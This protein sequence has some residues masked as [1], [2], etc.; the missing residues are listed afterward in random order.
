MSINEEQPLASAGAGDSSG[1]NFRK[2]FSDVAVYSTGNLLIKGLSLI[3]A[4]IFT[5]IFI[6]AQYGAWSYINV[7]VA[8]MTGILLLG[9]D[10]AYTRYFFQCESEEEKQTLTATWLAFLA[11]WSIV[12]IAAIL[13]FSGALASWMLGEDGYRAAWVIGLVSSPLAMM[14]LSLAQALRN[15]FRAKEFML[16]NLATAILTISL[17]VLFVLVFDLGVAGALLGA[18]LASLVMIPLRLWVI[19]DLLSQSFSLQFLKKLLI[20][21][22]PLVP[23]NIAFWLFSNA[24]RLMLARLASLEEVGIYSIAGSMAAVIML[25]QN[26]IGLSWLPHGIKTYEEDQIMAAQVFRKIMI[27]FLA[28]SGFIITGFV[29]LAQEVL[30]ILVP[31]AYYAAFTVIPFLAAGFIFFTSAHVSV[32]AIMV[33]NKTVY[34]MIACWAIAVLNIGLNFLLIPRFGI[35]GAGAATGISYMFFAGS[36]A[37]ISRQLWPVAYPGKLIALLLI[38]PLVAVGLIALIANYGP[39]VFIN[40]SLKILVLVISGLILARLANLRL[41]KLMQR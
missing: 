17:A 1:F 21:G 12:V 13:P 9:G 25:L 31:P 6:P 41:P 4:P 16:F 15:R 29:A 22:L 34:I 32:V 20:F 24:D 18:A 11:I 39:G 28:G 10:N 35:A 8:F 36:Y 33:K 37:L 3:S 38:V 40:F 14:N 7:M 2:L 27:T 23:M 30:F 5:R 26:A 19:R